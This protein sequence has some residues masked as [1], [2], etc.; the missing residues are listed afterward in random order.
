M[1]MITTTILLSSL[2][3]PCYGLRFTSLKSRL[4]LM[5]HRFGNF[6][7]YRDG[8][9][10]LRVSRATDLENADTMIE[11][12]RLF[13]RFSDKYMLLDVEGAGSP[14]MI[15]CCHSGCDNCEY[16]FRFDEMA[17]GRAKWVPLYA[18]RKHVDGRSHL[19]PWS[20]IF[21]DTWEDFEK[22]KEEISVENTFLHTKRGDSMSIDMNKF[23]SKVQDIP[24]AVSIGPP[25]GVGEEPPSEPFLIEFWGKLTSTAIET[26]D[27][28]H[29]TS[30]TAG[31]WV[32]KFNECRTWGYMEAVLFHF[33]LVQII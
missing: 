22:A 3:F 10:N 30:S 14:G 5:T 28:D 25:S 9:M 15:N 7:D 4:G 32:K 16:R 31:T 13:N 17:S 20:M 6:Q 26:V 24:P 2:L 23:I 12:A 21:F 27:S 29:L 33:R 18:D 8:L 11:T 1:L 19:A